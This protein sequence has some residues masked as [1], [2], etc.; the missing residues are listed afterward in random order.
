[1]PR[2]GKPKREAAAAGGAEEAE[3]GDANEAIG[4]LKAARASTPI[5]RA[6]SNQ[7]M[8]QDLDPQASVVAP[9]VQNHHS[10]QPQLSTGGGRPAQSAIAASGAHPVAAT[11]APA[12]NFQLN[13]SVAAGASVA[14]DVRQG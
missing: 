3:G 7:G 9:M 12:S 11:Q 14:T 2:D 8:D 10:L 6:N 13:V 1:M 5:S 4:E